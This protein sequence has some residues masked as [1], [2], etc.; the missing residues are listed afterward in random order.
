M[1]LTIDQIETIQL[2]HTS[3]CNLLCSQCAR[4]NNK[5]LPMKDLTVTDYEKILKPFVG[6]DITLFHCGNYGDVIVSPTF[7]ETLDYCLNLGFTKIKI[8]TNASARNPAWWANLAKLLGKKSTVTFAID[9]LEKTNHLYRKNSSWKKIS[10]NLESFI[11]AGGRARWHYILFDHNLDDL[12]PAQ[13]YAKSIGVESFSIKNSSRFLTS[14]GSE[15]NL[16][17]V[18]PE[19]N[20]KNID[21]HNNIIKNYGSFETYLENTTIDCKYKKQKTIYVDF[22]TRVWPCCWVGAPLFF[23]HDTI[24]KQHIVKVLNKYG[25]N[26]NSLNYHSWDEILHNNFYFQELENSWS[27]NFADSKNPRLSTCGRTCGEKFEFSSGYGQNINVVN[28]YE[29]KT[30]IT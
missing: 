16:L 21:D 3:R 22:E 13:Q 20:N 29:N 24:Q 19:P 4:T 15:Q 9:G 30:S 12:E 8:S 27:N 25:Y 6:K 14:Y 11:S 5:L 10:K 18:F 2:D 28:F 17:T 1:Y 7:D 26:F 23:A